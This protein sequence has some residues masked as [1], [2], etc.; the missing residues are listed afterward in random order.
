[1]GLQILPEHYPHVG[2]ALFGAIKVVLGE[3]ATDEILEAWGEAY[4]FLANIL[5]AHGERL[6]IDQE[7]A[8]GAA[9]AISK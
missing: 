9:G 1:M 7:T 2:E 3:A 5:I 8:A 4:W 6:H